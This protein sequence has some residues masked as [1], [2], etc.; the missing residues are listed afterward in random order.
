MPVSVSLSN[1]P[2]SMSAHCLALLLFLMPQTGHG[3]TVYRVG[4]NAGSSDIHLSW[5]ELA[6]GFGG[7]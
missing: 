3:A 7:D 2:T 5:T 4:G 1:W 6:T